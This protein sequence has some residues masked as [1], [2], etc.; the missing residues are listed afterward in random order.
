MFGRSKH[1]MD[2]YRKPAV[3]EVIVTCLGCGVALDRPQAWGRCLV[4][5]QLEDMRVSI[6]KNFR[7]KR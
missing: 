6:F 5:Q 7:V 3:I 4:C 1:S 2:P